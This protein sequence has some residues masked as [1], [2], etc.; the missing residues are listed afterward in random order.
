MSTS[1]GKF[2]LL[3]LFVV[4]IMFAFSLVSLFGYHVYLVLK[5]R[6]TL[7]AFRAP[8]FS[9]GGP[10]KNGFSLGYK[11][12]FEQVFGEDK[13]YWLLPIFTRQ[14]LSVHHSIPFRTFCVATL[15]DFH[16]FFAVLGM[17]LSILFARDICLK[18]FNLCSLRSVLSNYLD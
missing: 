14:V 17:A 3:F 4:A 1:A 12:N 10:D 6:T 18:K 7:E 8:I 13:R 2:H 16:H 11:K 9:I 5:N 15:F